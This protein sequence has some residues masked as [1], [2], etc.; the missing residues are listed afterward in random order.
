MPSEHLVLNTMRVK[1]NFKKLYLTNYEELTKVILFR[2]NYSLFKIMFNIIWLHNVITNLTAAK[3]LHFHQKNKEL[4]AQQTWCLFSK[5]KFKNA[6][7]HDNSRNFH[8]IKNIFLFA[9][10]IVSSAAFLSL[11]CP[12]PQQQT[13]RAFSFLRETLTVLGLF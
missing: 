1:Y 10:N 2:Y 5:L 7:S 12:Q 4:G 11:A 3:I 8:L 9:W 13:S 6:N